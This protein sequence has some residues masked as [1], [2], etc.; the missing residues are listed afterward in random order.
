[1][2]PEE[3]SLL[4]RLGAS[5]ESHDAGGQDF[6]AAAANLAVAKLLNSGYIS[7]ARSVIDMSQARGLVLQDEARWCRQL[8]EA[9]DSTTCASWLG[10]KFLKEQ[11][12]FDRR[13]MMDRHSKM[14]YARVLQL[15]EY[16]RT[17]AERGNADSVCAA[18]ERFGKDTLGRNSLWLKVVGDRKA[19]V[20]VAAMSGVQQG[21]N[22]LEIGTYCGYSAIKMAIALPGRRIDTLEVD[23]VHV[24]IARNIILFAGLA[25]TIQV[26]T[27]H[28]KHLIARLAQNRSGGKCYSGVFMDQRGS[29]SK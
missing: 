16:V 13:S 29:R 20:L 9:A 8:K 10:A 11:R 18:V 12:R 22:I 5:G 4:L 27:G 14:R 7:E 21:L 17:T 15:L 2:V 6:I 23:P 28:S 1:M 25:D 26:W 19:D 24:V 3:A